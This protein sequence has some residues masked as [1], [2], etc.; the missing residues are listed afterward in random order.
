[1]LSTGLSLI[2][3]AYSRGLSYVRDGLK[4]YMPYR[5]SDSD[6]VKFVGTA[7]TSFD[8]H[9]DYLNTGTGIGDALGDGYSDALTLTM[10]F[11][12]TG[13][14][15]GD[16]DGMFM[17]TDAG[18]W[19]DDKIMLRYESNLIYLRTMDSSSASIAYTETNVWRH[20]TVVCDRPNTELRM[21]LDGV[22][23][24]NDSMNEDLDLADMTTYIG[25]YSAVQYG[26]LGKMKNVAIW[27]RALTAT[28]VQNV[29]YKTYDEVGGRLA[30]GLV[31]WWALDV[32]YEDSK[33][34]NHGSDT[35][36][37]II[38]SIYGGAAPVK[39]RAIDN[40]PTV[41]A[42]GIGAGSALFVVGNTDYIS[43]SDDTSLDFGTGAFT[44]TVWMKQTDDDS[45]IIAK[46]TYNGV[47]DWLIYEK[48]A[49]MEFRN[50][51][52]GGDNRINFSGS[53]LKD[54]GW[55]HLAVTRDGTALKTYLDGVYQ[56]S[57]TL[58]ASYDFTNAHNVTIGAREDGSG[59]YADGNICQ[60]GIWDNALSQ[61][62]IQSVM[63]KTYDELTASEK[64]DL[65]SYW[66]L[67]VDATDSHGDND[68]TLE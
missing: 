14:A 60:V 65:V 30:N 32:S 40:A 47:G 48:E 33:G 23:K 61:A 44:I 52:N 56:N 13:T 11:K 46:G 41:Q 15:G 22:L 63:E 66:P 28:E 42:D 68:G 3:S 20:L 59:R 50:D 6:E 54:T 39:P 51:D 29:M 62:Q 27:N 4:L 49:N 67:D 57:G 45:A 19:S 10:W 9:T 38:K 55:H 37:E 31:S 24:T 5:G 34:S 16:E 26:F 18:D 12:A 2:K 43:I 21:Y 17:M 64:E 36:T 7:S 35:G 25:V 53:T 1:M 8:G 58:E